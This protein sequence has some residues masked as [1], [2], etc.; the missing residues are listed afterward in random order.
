MTLRE[1]LGDGPDVVV[2]GLTFDNRL[3]A[4]GTLFFCVPGF[5]RDGHDFAPDAVARGAVGLVV[6]RPLR[7]GVPEVL[8][9]DVR[10]AMSIA[11]ARFYGDPT[12]ELRVAGITGTNGKTTTAF[13]TRALLEG[14]GIR[15]G[16]L[17]TV[18]SVVGG[19]ERA[20][21]RTTPEAF[22]LQ[23]TFREMLDAG[24]AACAM[25]IS[26]HALELKRATG[27][28]VAAAVFTNLTQ[29][30][31]DFH[32]T[33]EDYFQAKRLLFASELTG[34]R[35]VNADSD[36]GRRLIEE[37]DCV[38]F[39]ISRDADYRA[40]DVR[41]D[42]TG[43]DFVVESP[44]GS[45]AA[46][47]PLPGRFNVLNALG[48]W[49]A[50]RAL[51]APASGLA[52]SLA[53]AATAP[54]RFQ[55]VDAGQPFGVVVDYAHKPDAL[56]QVLLAARE[57]ASGRLIVVVGAGGDRDRGKRP[58]M[59]EI[60]ARL[61]DYAFI[62][63]DNPRSEEPSAIIDEIVAGIPSSPHAVVSHDVDRRASIFR[64][65]GMAEPG[66][67]VVIAGKGHEQ[68]QEFENGRKEP[69]DDTTVAREA[70]AE[71]A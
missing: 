35:I 42:A 70:I 20:V 47:V 24:D 61:A 59:G 14:A 60:S 41:T 18:K 17:G 3:V 26:S 29:D 33:M 49:A 36:Y 39:A 4:P 22:D 19:E 21:V 25:E 57:M 46:R 38:T 15:T 13:L 58:I 30:H 64:A 68:G 40:V 67:V 34:A 31:L 9:D 5:T 37:F 1:L 28:H 27:I 23:R 51:G 2:T 62:T 7:L 56:E 52:D 45:F 53:H 8:V 55:P 69:F 11:A 10:E 12:K 65:I 16:L 50:A 71:R 32:P 44:D 63:S 54:G 66:D 43:C 48:A 6:Q